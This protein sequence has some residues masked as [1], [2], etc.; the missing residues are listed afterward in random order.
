M[1][2]VVGSESYWHGVLHGTGFATGFCCI[3]SMQDVEQLRNRCLGMGQQ[4]DLGKRIT[5]DLLTW[6]M[7][8]DQRE[9]SVL[10]RSAKI[11][12]IVGVLSVLDISGEAMCQ[13]APAAI[14]ALDLSAF[15]TI[16]GTY[17]GLDGGRNLGVTAGASLGIHSIGSF[18]PAI[19]LRGTY[20][21]VKGDVAS[22]KNLLG[23][24]R[25]SYS[26]RRLTPYADLLYGRGAI[27]YEN[28]GFPNPTGTYQYLQSPSNVLSPGA[29]VDYMLTRR[30][31]IKVD[32]QLQ[33]YSVPVLE[34]GTDYTRPLSVGVIYHFGVGAN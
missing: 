29:G 2:I 20:P 23:G 33:R 1:R 21:F 25:V 31:A 10:L 22:I 15:G 18:I 3:I 30:V 26:F 16:T 34:S 28:G 7:R 5:T 6:Q 32:L 11:L 27:H 12:M 14:R 8:R 24:V 9:G 17:T 13:S 4:E 19:E